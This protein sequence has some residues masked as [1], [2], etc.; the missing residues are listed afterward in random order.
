MAKVPTF[1]EP[2]L[3]RYL[4]DMLLERDR[5]L[6]GKLSTIA[7]NKSVLLYSPSEKV[8]EVKVDDAGVISATLVAG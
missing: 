5:L 1:I 7:A 6:A 8:Y 2:G 4:T 3:T